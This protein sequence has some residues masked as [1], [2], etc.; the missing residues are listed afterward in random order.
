MAY[1]VDISTKSDKE[2]IFSQKL[3]QR[4]PGRPLVSE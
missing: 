2:V 1:D 4:V 3:A